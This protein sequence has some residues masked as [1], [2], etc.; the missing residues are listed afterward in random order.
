MQE[1][2][3]KDAGGGKIRKTKMNE[4]EKRKEICVKEKMKYE[5]S[6]MEKEKKKNNVQ[7]K[8]K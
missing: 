4:Q 6:I 2:K 5:E 8:I 1:K 7:V 3:L